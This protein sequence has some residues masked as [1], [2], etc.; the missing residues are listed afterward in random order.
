MIASRSFVRRAAAVLFSA[1]LLG[2]SLADAQEYVRIDDVSDHMIGVSNPASGAFNNLL[3]RADRSPGSVYNGVVNLWLRDA[4][5]VV[6]GGC[7]GSLLSTRQILTAAHCV[8]NGSALTSSSF[9]A[10]FYEEG[11]GWV[12][13]NGS[14][15]AVKSG[16]TGLTFNENDVA[17]L[18]LGQDAPDFARRYSLAVGNVLN[19]QTTLAGYGRVGTILTGT[20]F[21][22]NQFNDQAILR[23]GLNTFET[24]CRSD[25]TCATALNPDPGAY[26]GVLLG[27]FDR[28]GESTTGIVCNSLGFCNAGYSDFREVTIGPGDSGSASFLTDWTISGVASFGQINNNTQRIGGGPGFFFG[29]ACVANV[30]GNAGC[31]SNY[32]FVMS[33]VQVPEPASIGLVGLGLFGLV[34]TARRRR[35]A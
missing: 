31:Q 19:Q 8:S 24:T 13:I 16:Y 17:V 12:D 30:S 10:R 15:Y 5:G 33:N 26:G 7:T 28:S 20:Q 35:A 29:Y 23:T 1:G 25:V 11:R 18:T 6:V 9:T 21:S 34:A 14:G 27:D 22:S 32:E 4:N 2:P 3:Y